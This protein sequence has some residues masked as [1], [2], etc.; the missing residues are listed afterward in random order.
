MGFVMNVPELNLD[1]PQVV[2]VKNSAGELLKS[3]PMIDLEVNQDISIA[4]A[5]DA[6]DVFGD[7]ALDVFSGLKVS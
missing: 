2:V 7:D 3:N 1:R 5:L 4:K 6:T